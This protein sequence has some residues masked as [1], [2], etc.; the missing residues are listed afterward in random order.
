MVEAMTV[1]KSQNAST[2]SSQPLCMQYFGDKFL[3]S[4]IL[5][6]SSSADPLETIDSID[7]T[8]SVRY[9]FNPDPEAGV[10]HTLSSRA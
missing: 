6:G 4:N 8:T 1:A 5:A 2:S 9:F 3:V 7:F 10:T